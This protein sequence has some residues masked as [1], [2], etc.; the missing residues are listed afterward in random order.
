MAT[1]E[2]PDL[3]DATTPLGGT[4]LVELVQAG[5]NRKTTP[6][7]F[8]RPL[9]TGPADACAG[10]DARLSDS[11][12]PNGA[13]GG[14][15]SGT[16]PAP[17]VAQVAGTIPGGVGLTVLASTTQAAARTAI[18][19]APTAGSTG[20][21]M[22]SDGAGGLLAT[23]TAVADL[24][25]AI[26][27]LTVPGIVRQTAVAAPGTP[28]EGERWNDSTRR[29]E[30]GFIGGIAIYGQ[31]ALASQVS[32]VAQSGVAEQTI[33]SPDGFGGLA[34]PTNFLQVGKTLIVEIDGELTLAGADTVTY[35]V[36]L[37]ATT[38]VSHAVAYVGAVAN[39]RF[40]LRA[41]IVCRVAGGAGTICAT[42][43]LTRAT[44]ANSVLL[45]STLTAALNLTAAQALNVTE[46]LITGAGG[47]AVV[48]NRATVMVIG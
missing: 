5:Q 36:K 32:D 2:I 47:S 34:L 44:A 28:V 10:D 41:A 46:Q 15:L 12:P 33:I 29:S 22:T 17:T 43:Q 35:R 26:P 13:A 11:R 21:V 24:N 48:S 38:V 7:S 20:Q 37:G 19:I 4:E 25:G 3:A 27:R 8:W 40:T 1:Y 16:F 23:A 30:Q 45:A 18:G 9:G 39:E 42:L 31:Q 14:D 6:D